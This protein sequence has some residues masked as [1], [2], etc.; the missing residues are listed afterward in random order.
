MPILAE[1]SI[2]DAIL[3]LPVHPLVVHA[4]VVILPLSALG[5]IAAV[6]VPWVRTRFAGLITLGTLA[7]AASAFVAKESGEALERHVGDP[8]VHAQYGEW[9]TIAG[10]VLAA[11]AVVWY[12]L[13]RRG[14]GGRGLAL[15]AGIVAV[16]A[17]LASLGLTVLVG[18]SGAE[19]AWKGTVNQT[20]PDEAGESG[21]A[22]E[23]DATATQSASP[24][25]S[26]SPSQSAS[27]TDATGAATGDGSTTT[28]TLANVAEHATRGDCWAAVDGGGYD[29]TS[30]VDRHP[31][32]EQRIL[33]LC[34]TD[35]TAAFQGQ[36]SGEAEPA[37]RLSGFRIG[38]L[39]G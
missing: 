19:Q 1:A 17:S 30:W 34:G 28:Y 3:G 23:S 9:A 8:G 2:F 27:P 5:L 22:G 12:L 20:A 16:V 31:G 33:N 10:F 36:H 7:G 39:Q 25:E 11:V 6:F 18:H 35:A 37:D 38:T 13:Q 15:L 26:A 24:T 32:G 21:E 14:S 4:A 29:L